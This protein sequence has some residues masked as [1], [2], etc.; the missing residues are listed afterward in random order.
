M[1][2]LNY[3]KLEIKRNLKL[4]PYLMIAIATLSL[5]LALVGFCATKLSEANK[6]KDKKN[7]YFSSEDDASLTK[8]VINALSKTDSITKLFN[9]SEI[10]Y[11]DV[12]AVAD[13]ENS[14]VTVV[15][16][17]GFLNSLMNGNNYPIK[18]YFS[19]TTSIYTMIITEL[20]LAAQTSLQ[21]AQSAVYTLYDY[22][23]DMGKY[24]YASTANEELNSTLITK[25]FSRNKFFVKKQLSS[26]GDYN[27][28]T[29]YLASGI[30]TVILLSGC[31]F[32]L[33]IK[34]TGHYIS[35]KLNQYGIGAFTQSIVKIFSVFFN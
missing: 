18:V 34:N 12:E 10:N 33:R 25:A 19:S 20:S 27:I 3:L 21:A 24:K 11:S 14:I 9:V 32:I 15:V 7:V 29:Y 28:K 35:L 31:I 23:Y 13:N 4:I 2:R 22:Y 16:P 6:L 1:N 5:V 8:L 30:L 26:T 17:K